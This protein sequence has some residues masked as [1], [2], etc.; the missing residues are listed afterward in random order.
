MGTPETNL[1]AGSNVY[2]CNGKSYLLLAQE[3]QGIDIEKLTGILVDS[4]IAIFD[5]KEHT[6]NKVKAILNVSGNAT[7]EI[8]PFLWINEEPIVSIKSIQLQLA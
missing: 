5:K 7:K 2:N 1:L 8:G 3:K 6:I 4:A